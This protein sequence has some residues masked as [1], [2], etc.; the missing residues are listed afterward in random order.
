MILTEYHKYFNVCHFL[1]IYNKFCRIA[2]CYC[3]I[4]DCLEVSSATLT[5][6]LFGSLTKIHFHAERDPISLLFQLYFE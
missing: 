1:I 3:C 5:A 2:G 6:Y 4:M